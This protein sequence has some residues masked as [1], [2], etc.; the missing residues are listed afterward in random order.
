MEQKEEEAEA[1][2]KKDREEQGYE[3]RWGQLSKRTLRLL[4]YDDAIID[5]D[6]WAKLSTLKNRGMTLTEEKMQGLCKG[7]GGGRKIRFEMAEQMEEA[8]IRLIVR[9]QRKQRKYT[10]LEE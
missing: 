6:G 3:N 4:R 8:K 7:K 5:K 10:P 1:D 9:V 2:T